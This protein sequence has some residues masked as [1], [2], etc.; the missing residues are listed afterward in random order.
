MTRYVTEPVELWPATPDAVALPISARLDYDAADPFAV[1][2]AFPSP[3]GTD[4]IT[5]V[6]SRA[7]LLDGIDKPTGC[8]DVH[9]APADAEDWATITLYPER[10]DQLALHAPRETIARFL[11]RTFAAVPMGREAAGIDWD[12]ELAALLTGGVG[13]GL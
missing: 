8:G 11:A 10:D 2:L 1:R 9:I 5:W 3:G 6:L 13:D 7:L 12:T 4:G